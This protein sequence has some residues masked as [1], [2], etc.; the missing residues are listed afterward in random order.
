MRNSTDPTHLN[1]HE[2]TRLT[3]NSFNPNTTTI[4]T[5]MDD[6]PPS[7][8]ETIGAPTVSPPSSPSPQPH[9]LT[10]QQTILVTFH[11]FSYIRANK[12]HRTAGRHLSTRSDIVL[13]TPKT[14]ELDF[15][16]QLLNRAGKL[17]GFEEEDRVA[18][19]MVL[20]VEGREDVTV[21]EGNWEAVE[22]FLRTA[23]IGAR[24]TM[25]VGP[26]R[27]VGVVRRV[28][29]VLLEAKRK[30]LGWALPKRLA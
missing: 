25:G 19:C 20:R 13:L 29:G 3:S 16:L 23:G 18:Y 4:I 6:T 22:R 10:L 27:E 26:V 5:M 14:S 21:S 12:S 30:V 17:F 9:Q 28:G 1:T 7:Y 2:M 8:T 24:L 15:G 11:H